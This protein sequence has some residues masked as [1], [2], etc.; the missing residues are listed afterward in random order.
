MRGEGVQIASKRGRG[1]KLRGGGEE[2]VNLK[3]PVFIEH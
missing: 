2:K 3:K 1:E